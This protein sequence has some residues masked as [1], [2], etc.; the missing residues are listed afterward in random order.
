MIKTFYLFVSSG[1]MPE[2]W[3]CSDRVRELL[4]SNSPALFRLSSSVEVEPVG[5]LKLRVSKNKE[6]FENF[7]EQIRNDFE[8]VNLKLYYSRRLG[9][10]IYQI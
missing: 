9:G 4:E 5:R 2:M 7:L 3:F 6:D 10:E 1:G 8:A